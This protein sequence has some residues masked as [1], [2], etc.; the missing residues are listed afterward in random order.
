MMAVY[1][2]GALIPTGILS[3]LLIWMPGRYFK[4]IIPRALVANGLAL[5]AATVLV[6]YGMDDDAPARLQRA[7]L[8][9]LA[10]QALWTVVW[11]IVLKGRQAS[12]ERLSSKR[13]P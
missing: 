11:L 7:F 1:F 6:G 5:V 2:L 10:P 3:A 12:S 8:E 9:F 13:L 4:Q